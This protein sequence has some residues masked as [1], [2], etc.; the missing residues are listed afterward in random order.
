MNSKTN[1]ILI[2]IFFIS[3]LRCA[4]DDIPIIDAHGQYNLACV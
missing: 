2:T 3:F 4:K 1:L